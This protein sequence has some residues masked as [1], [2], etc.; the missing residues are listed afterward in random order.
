M[1][2]QTIGAANAETTPAG[3]AAVGARRR[4]IKRRPPAAN[5]ADSAP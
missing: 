3:M 4:A 2:F 1:A 5:T